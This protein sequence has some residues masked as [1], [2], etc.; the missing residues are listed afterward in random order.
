MVT[1]DETKSN[2]KVA[3][4]RKKE[5]EDLA[6]ILSNKYGLEYIDLSVTAINTDALQLITEETAKQ[7]EMAIFN[8]IG[9]KIS[10][11]LR[12]PNNEKT[13]NTI[14]ELEERGYIPKLFM[15]SSASI[16]WAIKRYADISFA[17]ETKA[18]MLDISGEEIQ[19]II[20]GIKNIDDSKK[21]VDET[22]GLKKSHKVSR[23]L[24]V[25][26]GGG[27]SL[28]ASDVHIEP[29]EFTA[30]LRYRLDG[31]LVNITEID[32]ETYNLLLSRI[33]LI[34]GLKINLKNT[35]QD[36]RFSIKIN[37]GDV[38]I[39]T[40]MLP[41][42]YG[43]S[44]VMRI[45]NPDTISLSMEDL[46]IEKKLFEVLE[47]E[48]NKPNGMILVTG[49]TGSGKT[50]TLYAF[51]KRIQTPE[52]K[53]ITI[54]DPIE[55]H[56]PGIVQTQT[57]RKNYTF[58]NGLRSTL[59]QDPDIIMVGEIRDEEVASIAINAA[60]TGHLV[61]STLHTNN[62]AG[63]FPRL[64][65][66]DINP[67]IIS[68]SVNIVLAQRL[69]RKLCGA[70]KKQV[71]LSSDKKDSINKILETIV[72]KEIIP[73]NVS[74]VW[75]AAKCDECNNTGYKGRIG[76][77]EAVVMDEKIEALVKGSASER[78]IAN[79]AA[80]QGVLNMRQDG[81]LKVL[82]GITSLEELERVIE[83]L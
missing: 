55:Y 5:E 61:F 53:I 59:R 27:L 33:K 72:K 78:E 44:I 12:S 76:I 9:K 1:F 56:L 31:V 7:A 75:E 70:C 19:N 51:L 60:L 48:I 47:K 18:G 45:L 69:V 2:K 14:K 82:K 50:T 13:K 11:A 71:E 46:G 10:I 52:K 54:E 41:D 32:L 79:T 39:R 22:L 26:L 63:A 23:I 35:A 68:S 77:Y 24:E 29:E 80:S 73:K 15:V 43:E 28:K 57:D 37:K 6:S 36:G 67:K 30:R 20:N 3:D 66:L 16:K 38:E 40:S 65:D 25:V 49:P 83:V 34:S 64:I 42:A 21:L 4:L 62:A 81:I 8:K 17:V 58:G 74:T